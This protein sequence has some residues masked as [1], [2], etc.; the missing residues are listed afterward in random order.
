MLRFE[1][2]MGGEFPEPLRWSGGRDEPLQ[3]RRCRAEQR[4]W[5][6]GVVKFARLPC[7]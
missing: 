2:I 7:S 5:V 4:D 1:A 6:V 3:D